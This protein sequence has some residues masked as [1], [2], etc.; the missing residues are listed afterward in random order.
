MSRIA[1][2][3]FL[4]ILALAL[5]ILAGLD[6]RLAFATRD[7][8][9]EAALLDQHE[10]RSNGIG[11]V[12]AALLDQHERR[13][14]AAIRIPDTGFGASDQHER[15]GGGLT[16]APSEAAP[17]ASLDQHERRSARSAAIAIAELDQHERPGRGLAT[18]GR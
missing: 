15:A 11:A 7:L 4:A 17:F 14:A 18:A 8:S 10:R 6:L 13:A 12:T 1:F 5:T 3:A 2:L 16:S 9:S